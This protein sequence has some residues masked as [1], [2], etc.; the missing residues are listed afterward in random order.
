MKKEWIKIISQITDNIDNNN[1]M[2]CPVCGEGIDY[3]YVGDGNTRIGFLQVWCNKCLK[4]VYVSRV[5]A[6][7]NARFVTF[8]TDLKDVVPKYEFL[9]G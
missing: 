8:D 1:C 5:V 3:L 9:E 2:K 7:P 6:P 4:G